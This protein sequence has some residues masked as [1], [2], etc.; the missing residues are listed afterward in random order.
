LVLTV[1]GLAFGGSFG[2]P[3][4]Y[5]DK[6]YFEDKSFLVSGKKDGRQPDNL[7]RRER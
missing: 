5:T 1:S 4:V 6:R 3:T 7:S 2:E